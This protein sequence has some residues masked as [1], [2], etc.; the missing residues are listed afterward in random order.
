MYENVVIITFFR[1]VLDY[2]MNKIT[3]IK[4]YEK[5]ALI[6][7]IWHRA[8]FY[9]M[10]IVSA[11]NLIM[12]SNM[13]KSIRPSWRNVQGG[14]GGWMDGQMDGLDLFLYSLIPLLWSGEK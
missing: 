9:F 5:M 12:V 11:W 2:G 3:T 10:Y 7:Q 1:M 13:K 4:I 14:T 6:T 8:K